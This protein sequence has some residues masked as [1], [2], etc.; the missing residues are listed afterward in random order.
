MVHGMSITCAQVIYIAQ[1]SLHIMDNPLDMLWVLLI[2]A[3]A[4]IIEFIIVSGIISS[5]LPEFSAYPLLHTI[6]QL[7]TPDGTAILIIALQWIY[8]ISKYMR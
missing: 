6:L 4:S 7:L 3:I 8:L 5:F 2:G 1:K